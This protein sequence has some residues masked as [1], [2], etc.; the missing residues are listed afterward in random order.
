MKANQL[1]K[2]FAKAG[3]RAVLVG[4]SDAGA[5]VGLDLEGR[6]FGVLGGEVLSRVNTEAVLGQ[7]TREQYLNPG[8]D[9]L[10]PAPEGTTLGYE[11]STGAWRVPPGLRAARFHLTHSSKRS[12][13]VCAEV[14]LINNQ[15]LGIPTL[16]ARQI[17]I[18]P[19]RSAVTVRVIES[20]TY[21]GCR[22]LRR[23]ECLLAPW[24]LCQFDCG[25]G[26]EVV[27]PCKRKAA[28]WDLYDQPSDGQRTWGSGMCRTQTDGTQRYQIAIDAEVPW[29]EFRDPRRGLTVR[30]TAAPLPQGQSFLDIRDAAPDVLPRKKGVRYSVYSDLSGFM[31]IEAA[32]GCPTVLRSDGVMSVEISTRFAITKG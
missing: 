14:D 9:G 13:T 24:S 6:W 15:G 17:T 12:V 32:G 28:V 8:G 29:I 1:I 16:F 23:S 20:I 22:P 4:D 7:C 3:K 11:Y 18:S 25:P 2:L 19:G 31:E 27:F 5:I 26:C 10:W 30:R 21:L